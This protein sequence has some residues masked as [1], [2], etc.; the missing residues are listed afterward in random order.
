M[1]EVYR[2]RDTRLN[3]HVAIKVLPQAFATDPERLARFKREAHVLASLNHPHIAGIYGLEE[4]ANA[5]ALVLELVEGPTLADRIA[6]GPIPLDEAL[7][8]AKQICEALEA[9]HEKGIIHRDLKPANI[10]LTPNGTV[11]VLDFGLAKAILPD[12]SSTSQAALTNSPT[13][14][15]PIAL[16]GAGVLLGTAAYMSPEQARGK[17]VDKRADIWAFGC[18]LYEMLTGRR[19]FE[20]EDGSLTLSRVLQREPEFD[21]LPSNVPA[22]IRQ[23]LRLCLRKDPKQRFSDI[24]DVRLAVDG[25]FESGA[26]TTGIAVAHRSLRVWIAAAVISATAAV[27]MLVIH[28]REPVQDQVT[29]RYQLDNPA[30]ETIVSVALSP[31]GRKLAFTTGRLGGSNSA[32]TFNR[33]WVRSLD[34]LEAVPLRGSEGAMLP[35][36]SPDGRSIG[37]FADRKLKRINLLGGPPETISEANSL[38]SG[39]WNPED[40]VLFSIREGPLYAVSITEG[41]PRQATELDTSRKEIV[42]LFPQFL[43]DG[44]HFLYTAISS[45]PENSAVYVASLHSKDKKRLF[46]G[47]ANVNY[48]E[49]ANGLGYILFV[50]GETLIAQ[51]FDASQ[52]ELQGDPFPVAEGVAALPE[53][54]WPLA[55]FSSSVN[56][57]LTYLRGG[58]VDKELVWMD[59]SGRRLRTVG[60]AA[61]YTNLALSP[62]EKRLALTR[63]DPQRNTRDVWIL[64]LDRVIPSKLTFDPAD[65]MNPVWSPDGQQIAFSSTRK[66]QRDVYVKDTNST[67]EDAVLFE[68]PEDK[69]VAAWSPD[70]RYV[71]FGAFALPL[72]GERKPIALSPG[73]SNPRVS[74]DGRWLAYQSSQSGQLEIYVQSFPELLSRKSARKWQLST[75]G[76][77][78]AEWR[79]DGQELFYVAPDNMLMAVSIK[80]NGLNLEA[81]APK[82]L[83]PLRLEAV[84]RRSHYQ[85]ASD[86]QRFLVSQV[87]ERVASSPITVVVNWSAERTR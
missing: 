3:R 70:G 48:T 55:Q 82:P 61:D 44:S 10:K 21:A 65:E 51:R 24:R 30:S 22:S 73:T 11:K 85:P 72:Q 84:N 19:A 36:W 28:V 71:L 83:F 43:P 49:D 2:A 67:G 53:Y 63:R 46:A 13:I 9:A 75:A 40:V 54:E 58:N 34:S 50:R 6:Q 16:S 62:D 56:G 35:F 74:P 17:P 68:S 8:I 27:A 78:Y 86:G 57:I 60:E 4:T 76:G 23:A 52:M 12:P 32:S 26:E 14:T 1:G 15:S 64:D 81:A 77:N 69:S 45:V 87:P 59:R 47:N 20:D 5:S 66:G 7:P 42:H 80:S 39:T 37:F 29:L 31:D 25:A 33:I 18:V 38:S 79:G 41:K